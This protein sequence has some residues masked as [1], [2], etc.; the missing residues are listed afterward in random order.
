MATLK[1][2]KLIT[3]DV[4]LGDTVEENGFVTITKPVQ[5]VLDPMQ[6]GAGM[7]PYAAVF[8]QEEMDEL[9]LKEE[10]IVHPL[11]VSEPYE[12]AYINFKTGIEV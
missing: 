7:M 9:I 10:H 6:G 1:M 4:I 11:K 12:K 8:T 2:F 5:L 3:G